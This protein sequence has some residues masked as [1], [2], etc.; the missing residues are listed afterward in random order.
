MIRNF[1]DKEAERLGAAHRYGGL[2]TFRALRVASGACSAMPAFWMIRVFLR[3]IDLSPSRATA[4]GVQRAASPQRLHQT[5]NL[6]ADGRRH[7]QMCVISHQHARTDVAALAQRDL[8]QVLRITHAI[9]VGEGTR[10]PIIASLDHMW[11]DVGDVQSK[12]ARHGGIRVCGMTI[13]ISPWLESLSGNARL[14]RRKVH[15]GS[16]FVCPAFGHI[17]RRSTY[18]VDV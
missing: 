8:S 17:N 7:R 3:P 15:S 16:G 11:S 5:R 18:I 13:S 2:L 9:H 10:V 14:P 6:R 1:A 12:L 4:R